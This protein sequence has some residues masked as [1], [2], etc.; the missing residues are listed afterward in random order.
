MSL[1]HTKYVNTQTMQNTTPNRL[2]FAKPAGEEE[3]EYPTRAVRG[4]PRKAPGG[5]PGGVGGL[6]GWLPGGLQSI[7]GD[8]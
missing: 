6:L 2:A 8:S 7:L 3:W 1:K 5:L 4:L